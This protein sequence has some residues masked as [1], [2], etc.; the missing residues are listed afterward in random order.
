MIKQSMDHLPFCHPKRFVRSDATSYVRQP[1][2]GGGFHGL[3]D[4]NG[5]VGFEDQFSIR[6]DRVNGASIA[7]SVVQFDTENRDLRTFPAQKRKIV[8]ILAPE[9]DHSLWKDQE[10]PFTAA[11]IRQFQA[12]E[13]VIAATGPLRLISD[14]PDAA[15]YAM[16]ISF[17]Y[18]G[19]QS[20]TV[21]E[22]RGK[23]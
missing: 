3:G 6:G 18:H 20:I 11:G 22:D 21:E 9:L 12:A 15:Y 7:E 5:P 16:G 23:N 10:E 19:R 13:D 4:T 8:K 1:Q 2:A 14:T 17:R